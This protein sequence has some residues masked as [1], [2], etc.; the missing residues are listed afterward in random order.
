MFC[1][2][3]SEEPTR[4]Q[5]AVFSDEFQIVRRMGPSINDINHF[6]RFLTPPSPL[7]SILLNRLME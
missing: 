4:E 5:E 7:S 1:C 3:T 2:A 6:L